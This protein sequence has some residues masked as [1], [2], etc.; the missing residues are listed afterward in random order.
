M[1]RY[2]R[3]RELRKA[4]G[5]TQ[6]EVAELLGCSQQT[7]SDYEL[8]KRELSTA[9][10]ICLAQLYQTTTMYLLGATDYPYIPPEF[11]L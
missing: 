2:P 1:Y 4:A 7:Y 11:E 3:L 6:K 9:A 8:G 10:L 5:L